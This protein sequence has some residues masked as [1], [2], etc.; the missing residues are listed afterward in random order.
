M[1]WFEISEIHPGLD[2]LIFWKLQPN[3][4]RKLSQWRILQT[5]LSFVTRR[6]GTLFVTGRA[7]TPK[8]WHP[9]AL[10]DSLKSHISHSC[11]PDSFMGPPSQTLWVERRS[12]WLLPAL[13]VCFPPPCVCY[14]PE[15]CPC[16]WGVLSTPAPALSLLQPNAKP[17]SGT[18]KGGRPA[19]Q[20]QTLQFKSL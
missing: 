20:P 3:N 18:P 15:L 10:T 1:L 12:W 14:E 6:A 4:Q 7:A 13:S 17:V 16:R 19:R 5:F 2:N 8:Q 11:V 9:E